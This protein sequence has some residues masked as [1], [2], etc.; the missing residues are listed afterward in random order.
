MAR[1]SDGCV[2]LHLSAALVKFSSLAVARKYLTCCISI[3]AVY[4]SLPKFKYGRICD[5]AR[6]EPVWRRSHKAVGPSVVTAHFCSKPDACAFDCNTSHRRKEFVAG[7]PRHR[8]LHDQDTRDA[9][10]RS[11][12]RQ[13]HF[14][15]AIQE[16]STG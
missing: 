12:V 7:A 3:A 13:C 6:P 10:Y 2:T 4:L 5:A 16:R 15:M 8:Q 11:D 1:V 14:G 9:A